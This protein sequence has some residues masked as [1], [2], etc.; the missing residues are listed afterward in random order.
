MEPA[1]ILLKTC[2]VGEGFAELA[3]QPPKDD[4]AAM[5]IL[6]G[7]MSAED[8]LDRCR[9]LATGQS[10]ILRET[11]RRMDAI[12]GAIHDYM[13][14]LGKEKVEE[15]LAYRARMFP[16]KTWVQEA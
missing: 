15:H 4:F 10:D 7:L 8:I 3:K 9:S 12:R 6:D 13:K 11:N 1:Q 5:E 16:T 14:V 2:E